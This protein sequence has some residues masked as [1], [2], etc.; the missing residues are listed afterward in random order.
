MFSPLILLSFPLIAIL[1]LQFIKDE[2]N[3]LLVT[4]TLTLL[5]LFHIL[6]MI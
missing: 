3:Q 1:F 2:R 6:M 4:L 5:N